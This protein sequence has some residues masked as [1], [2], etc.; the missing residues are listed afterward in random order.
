MNEVNLLSVEW[1]QILREGHMVKCAWTLEEEE[2]KEFM[3]SPRTG[4]PWMVSRNHG[5]TN[6]KKLKRV[7]VRLCAIYGMHPGK[8]YMI[9]SLKDT[10]WIWS[11]QQRSWGRRWW[12]R[13]LIPDGSLPHVVLWR[14]ISNQLCQRTRTLQH[15]N[16]KGDIL[17]TSKL[18]LLME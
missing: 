18:L 15:R 6:T 2:V 12:C 9:V 8:L 7:L 17:G 3:P 13:L 16:D 5:V 10:S 4:H 14:L 11:W 1:Y